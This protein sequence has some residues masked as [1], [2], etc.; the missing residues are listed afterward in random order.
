MQ[1]LL[2]YLAWSGSGVPGQGQG[3]G[4][5]Q[6]LGRAQ[7]GSCL[8]VAVDVDFAKHEVGLGVDLRPVRI[9]RKRQVDLHCV[10]PGL[11]LHRTRVLMALG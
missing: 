4:L 10:H 1:L 6:D 8:T 5:D 2:R 7:I 11:G 3:L 9:L